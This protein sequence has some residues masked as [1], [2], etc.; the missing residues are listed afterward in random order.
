MSYLS[1]HFKDYDCDEY[2]NVYK[3]GKLLKQCCS[4]GYKQV[5]MRDENAKRRVCGVHC[6]VAMKYLNYFDGCVVHHKDGNRENNNLDNLEVYYRNFHSHLHGLNNESFKCL[7]KGKPA[8]NRG[9]KMSDEFCKHCSD[10]AK[11]RG[12]V[13][14]QFI[15]KFG[16]RR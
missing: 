2:G 6:V 16:N 7:N 5:T 15:D 11:K 3:C 4:N 10:S 1:I 13:G 12:F 14:N 9:V 8:W